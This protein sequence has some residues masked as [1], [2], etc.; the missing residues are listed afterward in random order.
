MQSVQENKARKGNSC[1]EVCSMNGVVMEL[2]GK[3]L[4]L[5]GIL[6]GW[7]SEWAQK[8]QGTFWVEGTQVLRP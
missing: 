8:G 5:I 6:K 7:G 1:A 2:L 4:S 3:Y